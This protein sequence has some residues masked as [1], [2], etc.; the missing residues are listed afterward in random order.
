MNRIVVGTAPSPNLWNT[1]SRWEK[2]GVK[3]SRWQLMNWFFL[4]ELA[5]LQTLTT[6]LE[7]DRSHSIVFVFLMKRI[8][9]TEYSLT[10]K[11]RSRYPTK[12]LIGKWTQLVQGRR[13]STRSMFQEEVRRPYYED[14][15]RRETEED[16][17]HDFGLEVLWFPQD[18]EPY[19]G[20]I[21]RRQADREEKAKLDQQVQDWV[22]GE[23]QPST[24]GWAGAYF[25]C[26]YFFQVHIFFIFLQVHVFLQL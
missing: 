5:L 14:Q 12:G 13:R 19:G 22:L 15:K 8:F 23:G 3:K 25:F 20:D 16:D 26:I 4:P 10:S 7:G 9:N 17:N 24:W 18:C 11:S 2:N 21:R 6:G 1:Q